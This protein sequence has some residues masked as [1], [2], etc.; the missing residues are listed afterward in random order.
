MVSECIV[1]ALI[2]AAW[3]QSAMAESL[4]LPLDPTVHCGPKVFYNFT[5]Q[6]RACSLDF[7]HRD[8]PSSECCEAL[9][10]WYGPDATL[11]SRNCYCDKATWEQFQEVTKGTYY[12]WDAAFKMCSAIGFLVPYYH[13][14]ENGTAIGACAGA[15]TN[16]SEF[17]QACIDNCPITAAATLQDWTARLHLDPLVLASVVTGAFAGFGMLL[18][19]LPLGM[20]MVSGAVNKLAGSRKPTAQP[21]RMPPGAIN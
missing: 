1:T 15:P 8:D 10:Q 12:T 7:Y 18:L 13:E 16:I 6:N 4:P 9:A 14:D 17:Q 2:F 5:K 11:P 3:L 19:F 21:A 20:D